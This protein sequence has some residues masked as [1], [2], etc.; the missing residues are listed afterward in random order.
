[1]LGVDGISGKFGATTVH[2]GEAEASRQIA[3]VARKVV[4]AA[5][6]PSPYASGQGSERLR[7]AGVEVVTGVCADEAAPLYAVYRD[8]LK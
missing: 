6:D 2:E 7:R 8:R 4:V 5:D 1:M 3:A